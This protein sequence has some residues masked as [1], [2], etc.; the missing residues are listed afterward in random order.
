MNSSQKKIFHSSDPYPL[1]FNYLENFEIYLIRGHL[2]G[3]C[4]KL[5][6]EKVNFLFFSTEE[7][8]I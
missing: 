1:T 6:Y 8:S 3:E 7:L 2:L 5:T 4:K